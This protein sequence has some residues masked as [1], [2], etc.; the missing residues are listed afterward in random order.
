MTSFVHSYFVF[1][2]WFSPCTSHKTTV[3]KIVTLVP[4][5]FRQ[6]L[7]IRRLLIFASYEKQL[8]DI[9]RGARGNVPHSFEELHERL[10]QGPEAALYGRVNGRAFYRGLLGP[11][12]QRSAIFFTDKGLAILRECAEISVDGTFVSRPSTPDS[13]QLLMI[14]AIRF[15]YVS[16]PLLLSFPWPFFFPPP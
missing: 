14:T 4:W 5:C 7:Q 10:T 2:S 13:A 9:R 11:P 12:G 16:I 3:Y 6:P 15:E 1:Y 8:G